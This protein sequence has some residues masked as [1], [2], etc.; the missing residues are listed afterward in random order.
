[1]NH[2]LYMEHPE[3][4][5]FEAQI[6]DIQQ[7][8]DGLFAVYLDQS[9]FYP[10]GGGQ[11]HDTGFLNEGRV[12][13]VIKDENHPPSILHLVDRPLDHGPVT[14][15]IDPERRLRHMQHH[16]GQ[17]LLTQC[18]LQHLNLE[19]VSSNING[20]S[21]ST[22][23]LPMNDLENSQIS[24]VERLANQIVFENRP[25][26]AFF[27]SQED[28]A[29]LP[30]RKQPPATSS[31]RIV[32]ISGFDWTPCAGTHCSATAQVGI[33]KITRRERMRD[34]LRIH[35]VAGLQAYE[36][37]TTTVETISTL[38]S[39]FSLHPND[40]AQVMTSQAA[41][42]KQALK[43]LQE[44]R[45]KALAGEALLLAVEAQQRPE[46]PESL[47]RFYEGRPA[48]ELR[49]LAEALRKRYSG[50]AC[51]FTHDGSKLT[52]IVICGDK[53]RY[54]ARQVLDHWLQPLGGKGGGDDRIA[55][56]GAQL[57]SEAYQ[58]IIHRSPVDF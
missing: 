43:D 47:V 12:L 6:L 20:Y 38:S 34:S 19:T 52:A 9:F 23:D 3:I 10:T 15:R 1:M 35:F 56:G 46:D 2:L 29:E 24:A 17:H 58:A 5:E 33:I 57:T 37:F 30:L 54:S 50:T 40:L 53:S 45:S 51:L 36:L 22:L 18:F 11:E 14:A 48:G 49:L 39:Q 7:R 41:Q 8:P 44:Q 27:A 26:R 42:L 21:P 31:V 32:E 4:L 28:L 16:T 55:Q 13:D 25:V